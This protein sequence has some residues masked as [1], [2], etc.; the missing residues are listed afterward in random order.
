MNYHNVS[1]ERIIR[2]CL[3]SIPYVT[4]YNNSGGLAV[5]WSV[6]QTLKLKA[7]VR[8]R[9]IIP[10][11]FCPSARHFIHIADLYPGVFVTFFLLS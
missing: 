5:Y 9:V 11:H 1:M 2:T 6:R 4:C 10:S 7:G 3:Y 8:G